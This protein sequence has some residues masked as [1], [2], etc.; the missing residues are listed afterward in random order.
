MPS[1]PPEIWE[2]L[3]EPIPV[4]ELGVALVHSKPKKAPGPDGLTPA[5]YKAFF[6]VLSPHLTSITEGKSIPQHSLQ[7]YISLIPKKGKDLSCCKNYRAIALLNSDLRMFAKILANWLLPY[8]P[9]LIHRD[10]AGFV[11]LR[12]PWDNTIRVLN[13]IH[14]ART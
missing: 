6:K 2:E 8:T 7:A 10:Q 5:Y 13:L 11:Q 9:R 12:E 3:E 14:A 4:E 1:L